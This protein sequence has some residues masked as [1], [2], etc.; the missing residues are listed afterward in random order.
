VVVAGV[1]DKKLE[2]CVGFGAQHIGSRRHKIE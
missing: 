1:G 2:L